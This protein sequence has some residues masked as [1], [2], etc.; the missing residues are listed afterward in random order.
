MRIR[1][2]VFVFLGILAPLL[3]FATVEPSSVSEKSLKL[4]SPEAREALLEAKIT[5]LGVVPV[6]PGN[7]QSKE[8]VELGRLLYF[9]KRLSADKSISCASCHDPK[10]GWAEKEATSTGIKKQKGARNSPSVLN[11]AYYHAM[12]WDGRAKTLEEQALGPIQNPI[13]MGND[14]KN[15][16]VTLDSLAGY[17]PLFKAAFG[18][19]NITAERVAMAIASFERTVVT[20]PSPFD[21]FLSGNTAALSPQQLKGLN[22]FL[23][24]GNCVS[25]H[26][27]AFLT[28]QDYMPSDFKDDPGRAQ[29]TKSESDK[30]L[31]RV[32]S[33]RNVGLTGPYFHNGA[34]TGLDEAV[35]MR[36]NGISQKEFLGKKAP[37]ASGLTLN[38]SEV[39][40][41]A[42]FLKALNGKMPSILEPKTFP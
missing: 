21:E 31:F 37:D 4:L 30:G 23:T 6:P 39:K 7:P 3:Y 36:A 38:Q 15:M 32:P 35:F 33:L 34:V 18:D 10:F 2:L 24:K 42:A 28:S 41:V 27:G 9:D 40:D 25:C 11:S 5:P 13:E 16:V 14:L 22:L 26:R 29:V 17:K 20:G 1:T 8:K 12:F 19:D